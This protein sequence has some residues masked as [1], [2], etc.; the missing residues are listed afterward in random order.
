MTDP[1]AAVTQIIL[2]NLGQTATAMSSGSLI[3]FDAVFKTNYKIQT[4]DGTYIIEPNPAI[5]VLTTVSN[6]LAYDQ[7]IHL[8]DGTAWLVR[9]RFV[10]DDG[11]VTRIVI[12]KVTP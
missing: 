4:E 12:A 11:E 5:D 6:Q 1:F 8:A 7:T 10:L 3:S 9:Q 2:H